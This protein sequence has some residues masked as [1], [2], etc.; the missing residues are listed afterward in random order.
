MPHGTIGQGAAA[1]AMTRASVLRAGGTVATRCTHLS[2]EIVSPSWLATRLS[3]WLPASSS[4]IPPA[5]R[6][7]VPSSGCWA[8]S[9]LWSGS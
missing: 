1:S 7:R 3:A 4:S 5:Q 2:S 6:Q 8:T 9:G